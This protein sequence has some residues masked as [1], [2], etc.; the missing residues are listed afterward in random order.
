MYCKYGGFQHP[1]NEAIVTS[2]TKRVTHNNR[3][4]AD[5]ETRTATVRGVL[6]PSDPPTQAKLTTLINSL[7]TAY[8]ADG[9]D[10]VFFD[11]NDNP[12][13]HRLINA[14]SISGVRVVT[15]P[16]FPEGDGAEYA[17]GRTYEIVLEADF[18][19]TVGLMSFSESTSVTGTGGP[20]VIHINIIN[21]SPVPQQVY[22]ATT[23]RATQAGEEVRSDFFASPPGRLFGGEHRDLPRVQMSI[24]DDRGRRIFRTTWSY[25]FES[26]NLRLVPPHIG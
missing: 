18:R 21:G 10:F 22:P 12:T 24:G 20:K 25:S 8:A 9:K 17:T 26:N 2:F 23:V 5:I 13:P 19:A 11:D 15:K 4:G 16:S 1:D 14:E 7:E 6:I 3:G